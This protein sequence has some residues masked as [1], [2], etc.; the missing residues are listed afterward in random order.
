MARRVSHS[1]ALQLAELDEGGRSFRRIWPE[2]AVEYAWLPPWEG[3]TEV[4]ANRV[5]V[6][7][8]GH[9][10]VA[11]DHEGILHDVRARPG[12]A[13]LMGTDATRL[14]RIREH[15]D[16]LDMYPDMSLLNAEAR[17]RGFENFAIAPTL[18]YGT[19]HVFDIQ[20]VFLSLAHLF[21]KACIG[22][23]AISD[24]EA[25]TLAYRLIDGI[26]SL[27]GAARKERMTAGR[28]NTSALARVCDYVEENLTQRLSLPCLAALC[29]LSPW[30]FAVRF[31]AATGVS[32]GQYV[33][34]RRL[35]FAKRLVMTTELP[36]WDIAW[37]AGFE[38]ISHFRRQ[39]R[40]HVG[41]LP[42][43]LRRATTLR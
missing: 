12:G 40:H 11:V 31:K 21:R 3:R 35:E 26:L 9:E 41:L 1:T 14:Q 38:N 7:F 8:S 30:H 32:P 22:A 37:S 33:L 15:S 34:G 10:S 39:F 36:V 6:V 20:P 43:E 24:V 27:Q 42:G 4:R 18:A 16:T 25:S 13:Y 5:K 28:L 2:V 29:D 23:T 19:N 17:A